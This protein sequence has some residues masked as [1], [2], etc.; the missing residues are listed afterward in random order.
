MV[1]IFTTNNVSYHTA[2]AQMQP[3]G[4]AAVAPAAFQENQ[5]MTHTQTKET[6]TAKDVMSE[7]RRRTAIEFAS[8][9]HRGKDKPA[10]E[11]V[12]EAAVFEAYLRDGT[13]QKEEKKG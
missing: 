11:I 2:A 3:F 12:A 7:D 9:I 5:Q 4:Q 1:E 10:S 8:D 13:V 6:A